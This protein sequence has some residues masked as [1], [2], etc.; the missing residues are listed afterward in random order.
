M[1]KIL[2]CTLRDGGYYTNWD[3]EKDLTK[4]Y[5]KYINKLPIEYVEVGYKS[6]LKNEYLGEYYYLPLSTLRRIKRYTSKKLSIMLNAKD[7]IEI[8]VEILLKNTKEFISLVRIATD[9]NAMELSLELAK[10]IK[11]LGFD[12][13]INVMYISRID[14][15]HKFF[16]YLDGIHDCIDTLN[17]VDSY[18]SIYPDELEELI[19]EVQR[20]T[21]IALGFH[22]HNN[23]ELAF[24]NTLKAIE[25]RAEYVDCTILGMGRGAGN[26]KTELIL[27]YLKSKKNIRV[28]LNY[29]GDLTELFIPLQ[30]KYKW[31]T[32]LAYMVSG[33]YSLTQKDVMDALAIDR[34][35]LSGIVNQLKNDEEL[36]LP[37]FEFDK[38][39]SDCMIIGGGN[40]VEKHIE[41]IVEFLKLNQNTLI[42]HSTSKHI[43]LFE[44]LDNIQYLA[45]AGD[46]LLKLH[47]ISSIDKYILESSPRKVNSNVTDK[48]DFY[49]LEKIDFIS[50]YS[51]APLAIS[52]QI[53]LVIKAKNIYLV[54]FDGYSE[55]KNKKELYLMQENQ[56]I[57]DSFISKNDLISLTSTKYKNIHQ[58]SIYGVIQC[59]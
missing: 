40:S 54:G 12:V 44:K 43:N 33:S 39:A 51:D 22:G 30:A 21:S 45:V 1:V 38:V 7:C 11:S 53:S 13:A 28:D 29:L 52:L 50:K 47:K 36:T 42:V 15:N 19:Y 57:I 14:K 56:E 55:L 20:K 58:K 9:P 41:V 46:E 2:D 6:A 5:F 34:Y 17:L 10:K 31:G 4:K 59:Q 49:E 24:I 18:G 16:S 26:L 8:D 32:N 48:M 23:L 27:T 3:F 37:L 25:C 35:S